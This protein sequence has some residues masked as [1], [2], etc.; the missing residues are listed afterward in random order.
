MAETQSQTGGVKWHTLGLRRQ[1]ALSVWYCHPPRT[2][3]PFP[4]V[5]QEN[6]VVELLDALGLPLDVGFGASSDAGPSSPK[7]GAAAA[8][9]GRLEERSRFALAGPA[10][11]SPRVPR[12]F[13]TVLSLRGSESEDESPLGPSVE[14]MPRKARRTARYPCLQRRL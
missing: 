1:T 14:L 8:R 10:G 5:V 7:P 4:Q 3:K 12:R 13:R 11:A 6:G 2:L 9:R